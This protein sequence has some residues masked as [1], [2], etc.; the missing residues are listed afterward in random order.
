MKWVLVAAL[1][2]A[3]LIGLTAMVYELVMN[4]DDLKVQAVESNS[5]SG[6]TDE[7]GSEVPVSEG[8]N[9]T[10]GDNGDSSQ[11]NKEDNA[12][13]DENSGDSSTSDGD[14]ATGGDDGS[15]SGTSDTE[16]LLYD[17]NTYGIPVS[18]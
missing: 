12:T 14:N 17:K 5:G 8:D 15:D 3:V 18:A 13:G 2:V 6:A 7:S 11:A 4:E 10:T 1:A 16:K 9:G